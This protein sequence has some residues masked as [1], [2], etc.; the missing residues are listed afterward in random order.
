M[1]AA[2]KAKLEKQ[3]WRVG[4]AQEFLGL[5][6]DENAYI[7]LKLKLAQRL[8]ARR[9]EKGY[10]Q[11]QLATRIQSNQ[12]RVAKMEAGDPGVTL[13]AIIRSLI[14]PVAVAA[15][16]GQAGTEVQERHYARPEAV[17]AGHQETVVQVLRKEEW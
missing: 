5:S 15:T 1:N 11:S 7:E 3:G 13:D 9:E 6:D 16:L 8:R 12:S 14:A 10:T 17:A 2:K 4:T